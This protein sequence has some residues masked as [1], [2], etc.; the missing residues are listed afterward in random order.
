MQFDSKTFNSEA[1]GKYVAEVPREKNDAL[2]KSGALVYSDEIKK[3]LSTQT[4]SAYGT[5]PMFGT[6]DGDAVNYDG[7][8][9]IAA[10]SMETYSRSIV[11]IGRAKAWVERDFSYDI[12][13][14]VDFISQVG[15][16]VA[17][18]WDDVNNGILQ[19]ILDGIFAMTGVKNLE[20]VN[21]HT[22]DISTGETNNVMSAT[23]LNEAIQK[24]SGDQKS[25]FTMVLMHSA[26]ATNLENLQL[27]Q[28]GKYTD[29]Q[30]IQR[31]LALTTWNGKIVIIDDG[32]PA[33]VVG[34]GDTAYT[35]YTSYVLGNGAIEYA[36]L[37]VDVPNEMQRDPAKYGGQTTLY[38][39]ERV[40][41]APYGLSYKKAAQATLSPTNSELANGANWELATNG[42]SSSALKVFPHKFIPIA[43]IIS[44][45]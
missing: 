45:G 9:D 21:N 7:Q 29:S 39:R 13:S 15:T 44:R 20:F 26:V 17:G 41:Y 31:D 6:I 38:T 14:G 40:A 5:I 16:Q 1:F 12:T 37:G 4:G 2:V 3:L 8:T 19:S 33:K 22:H 18:Y 35:E 43:R 28:Y 10:T 27:L 42:K 11:A 23:T 34:D 30:G 36:D 25:K 24:A 32:L